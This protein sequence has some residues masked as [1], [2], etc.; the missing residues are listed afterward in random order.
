MNANVSSAPTADQIKEFVELLKQR[1]ITGEAFS[2]ALESADICDQVARIM[3]IVQVPAVDI[4]GPLNQNAIK[5]VVKYLFERAIVHAKRY[6]NVPWYS[7]ESGYDP[8]DLYEEANFRKLLV[9]ME[10][11]YLTILVK[12]N[13][14]LDGVQVPAGILAERYDVSG[15]DIATMLGRANKHMKVRQAEVFRFMST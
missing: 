5:R 13:G 8:R 4:S 2:R 3:R 7:R 12:R 11:Q 10:P 9:D 1:G 15:S 14:L 6:D